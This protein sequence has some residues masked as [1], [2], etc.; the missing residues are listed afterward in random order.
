[1]SRMHAGA[2]TPQLPVD[3][4]STGGGD[5]GWKAWRD[6]ALRR[7]ACTYRTSE[8]TGQGAG[9]KGGLQATPIALDAKTPGAK[10]ASSLLPL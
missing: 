6:P 10:A 7:S 3:G 8:G 4:G 5:E 9:G 2:Q 1:M